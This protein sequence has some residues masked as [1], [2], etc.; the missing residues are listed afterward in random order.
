MAWMGVLASVAGLGGLLGVAV[1]RQHAVDGAADLVALSAA[2]SAQRGEPGC[3][4]ARHVASAN[5]VALA[6]CRLVGAD[7]V[8]AVREELALPFGLRVQVVGRAR[9]GPG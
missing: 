4:V 1:S 8:V 3:E 5:G 6:A 2:A 9:A 7:V